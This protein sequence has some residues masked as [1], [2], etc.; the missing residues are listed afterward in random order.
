MDGIWFLL[1]WCAVDD[2]SGPQNKSHVEYPVTIV[3]DW[4]LDLFQA[5]LL[6]SM[7]VEQLSRGCRDVIDWTGDLLFISLR[8]LILL[9]L[10]SGH[11]FLSLFLSLKLFF[12]LFKTMC[13]ALRHD[14]P[15]FSNLSVLCNLSTIPPQP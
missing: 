10:P 12:R 15:L 9:A 14:D 8:R 1:C 4:N 7:K 2:L 6:V 5:Y 3:D 13:I 11:L